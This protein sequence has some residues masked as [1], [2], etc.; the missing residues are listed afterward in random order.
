MIEPI[1]STVIMVIVF[2]TILDRH[3]AS[4]ALYIICGRLLFSF[5]SETTKS[6]G[7]SIRVNSSMI[8]KVYV[9]KYLYPF[10]DALWHFVVFAVSLLV[11]LPVSVYCKVT[12]TL[13]IW[14]VVP[15]LL[16][17]FLFSLGLGFLLTTMNVFLR[18]TE[19]LWNVTTLLVM[20]LSAIFYYPDKLLKSQ[21][22]FF[23]QYNPIFCIITLFRNGVLG[24]TPE[25][26]YLIYPGLVSVATLWFGFWIFRKSED[27]FAFYV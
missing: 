18:D 5:F 4:F 7:K 1:L 20:Y 25:P 19:Y 14:Q 2:G 21:W 10:S 9:P 26:F 22:G 6:A 15:A 12:P 13:M 24:H 17:L 23:I 8:K 16:F 3:E 11:I 27:K